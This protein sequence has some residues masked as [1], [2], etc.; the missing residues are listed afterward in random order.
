MLTCGSPRYVSPEQIGDYDVARDHRT[1]IYS[2]GATLY[3]M[4]TG[5]PQPTTSRHIDLR[6][7][8][9]SIAVC[10]I[11]NHLAAEQRTKSR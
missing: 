5:R 10:V 1:D 6:D 9:D 3:E 4:A 11:G 8:V 2:L 7:R